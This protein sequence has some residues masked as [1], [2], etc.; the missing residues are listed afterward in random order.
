MK[1]TLQTAI[2]NYGHTIPLK[3]GSV[4]SDKFDMKH[5]EVS[6]I[7]MIFRRMVRDLEFDVS[8]MALA[9]HICSRH[10][11][12]TFT[13]LPIPIT[14]SFPLHALVCKE[15][16]S[17]RDATDLKGK[18][19]GVRSY[20]FTPGTWIRA[21]LQDVY[22]V[23]PSDSSWI[24]SGD[25]HV[26]EYSAPPYVTYSKNSDL[27]EMLESGEIDA[28]IYS[29]TLEGKRLR[30]V[31]ENAK[32][33]QADWQNQHKIDP[34]SHILVVKN[35]LLKKHP[36]L[37]TELF[38]VYSEARDLYSK[39]QEGNTPV[40]IPYGFENEKHQLEMFVSFMRD[41]QLIPDIF[42]VSKLFPDNTLQ[43]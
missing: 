8:E 6:P 33:V 36:W 40:N 15:D 24:I 43:L 13:A 39:S 19:I 10:E 41:Q 11:C 5:I 34:I 28:A 18:N 14:R 25:E 32:Q 21:I 29:D 9:T 38:T 23:M 2:G 42:N 16:S 12:K 35:D 1:L 31:I 27:L 30:P 17:I 7:P 26:A 20:T 22:H 4:V 37:S 3:N